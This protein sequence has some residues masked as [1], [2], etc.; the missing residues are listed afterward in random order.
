MFE[1]DEKPIDED[2]AEEGVGD[3]LAWSMVLADSEKERDK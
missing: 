3:R 2:M 1:C